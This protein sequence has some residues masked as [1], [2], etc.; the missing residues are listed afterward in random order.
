MKRGN[1]RKF[2][3]QTVQR[4]ALRKALVTSLIEHGRIKT[5]VAKAKTLS[6]IAEKLVTYARKGD[7]SSR[8]EVARFLGPKA[9][10]KLFTDIAPKYNERKGGY[11]R[12]TKLGQRK[13]DSAPMA[14]IELIQ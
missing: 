9:V 14:Y 12:I 13:S 10:T 1:I 4:K 8:R 11:T 5:T 7:M 2:G 6:S 3:R